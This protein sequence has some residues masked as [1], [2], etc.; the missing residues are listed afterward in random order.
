MTTPVLMRPAMTP[1][2]AMD[3]DDPKLSPSVWKGALMQLAL[4]HELVNFL[5]LHS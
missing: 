3:C 4:W 2:M 5:S 1:W